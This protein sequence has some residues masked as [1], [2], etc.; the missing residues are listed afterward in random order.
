M[1]V[2]MGKRKGNAGYAGINTIAG[3]C[4]MTVIIGD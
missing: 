4:A 3:P 2:T 1:D